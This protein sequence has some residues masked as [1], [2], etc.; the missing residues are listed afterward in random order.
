MIETMGRDAFC[1][2]G[3]RRHERRRLEDIR[4]DGNPI[5][6]SLFPEAYF[7]LPRLPVGRY[8]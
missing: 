4:L 6:L 5:N 7:C 8:T 2:T 3:E 1:D